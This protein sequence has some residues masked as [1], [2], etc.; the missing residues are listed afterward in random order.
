[1]VPL[2]LP[3]APSCAHNE[4]E[5]SS[6]DPDIEQFQLSDSWSLISSDRERKY[7]ASVELDDSEDQPPGGVGFSDSSL[8]GNGEG[9]AE[10]M[11]GRAPWPPNAACQSGMED[12]ESEPGEHD[13]EVAPDPHGQ[14]EDAQVMAPA[15]V[16]SKPSPVPRLVTHSLFAGG[17]AGDVKLPWERSPIFSEDVV[18]PALKFSNPLARSNERDE[19][20]VETAST[21]TPYVCCFFSRL[22]KSN[23]WEARRGF[24]G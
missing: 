22:C 16:D 15:T 24:P 10:H 17:F 2:T 5:P 23:N 11:A 12:M 13:A 7:Y 6:V 3:A 14:D 1:M 20:I 8:H 4:V 9:E 21:C 18:K 19:L